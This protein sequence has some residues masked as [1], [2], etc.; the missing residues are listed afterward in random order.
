MLELPADDSFRRE[1]ESISIEGNR[2]LQIVHAERE[3]GQSWS[4][5][6]H[7]LTP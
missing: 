6:S 5:V 3:H 4:H 2:T 7:I 1:A